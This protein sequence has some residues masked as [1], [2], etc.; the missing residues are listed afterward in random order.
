MKPP[1]AKAGGFILP[2]H[3]C[4]DYFYS[5]VLPNFRYRFHYLFTRAVLQF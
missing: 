3:A 1:A 5:Y 2:V 4:P